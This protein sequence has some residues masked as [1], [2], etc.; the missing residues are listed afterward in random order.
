MSEREEKK[1]ECM[2]SMHVLQAILS[3]HQLH[4]RV[5]N[6]LVLF[7]LPNLA[8]SLCLAQYVLKLHTANNVFIDN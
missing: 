6:E 5:H 3:E 2:F 8:L 1:I 7:F 4:K